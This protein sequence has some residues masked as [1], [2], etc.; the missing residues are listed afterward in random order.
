MPQSPQG[1]EMHIRKGKLRLRGEEVTGC[2]ALPMALHT[3]QDRVAYIFTGHLFWST[4]DLAWWLAHN[5]TEIQLLCLPSDRVR[6]P[7]PV[8]FCSVFWVYSF[9]FILCFKFSKKSLAQVTVC[10]IQPML[11]VKVQGWLSQR[12]LEMTCPEELLFFNMNSQHTQDSIES[13][14][15]MFHIDLKHISCVLFILPT[16]YRCLYCTVRVF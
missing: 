8:Y 5:S 15:T 2:V 12:E 11:S 9:Q 16:P 6:F 13:W 7:A 14:N 10:F 3:A 1:L 4:L